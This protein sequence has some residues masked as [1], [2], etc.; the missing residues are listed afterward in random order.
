MPDVPFKPTATMMTEARMRVM[1]VIPLTGLEPTMAMALAATVVKRK[2][3][4]ATSRIATRLKRN[5]PPITSHWKKRKVAISA[6]MMPSATLRMGM[7][8]WV[9]STSAPSV[10]LLPISEAASFTAPT[11]SFQLLTIPITP[12]MAIPPIPMLLA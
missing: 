10:F 8:R 3:M 2:V 6:T 12:A 7:S 4:T 11:M 1:S 9:R 5:T